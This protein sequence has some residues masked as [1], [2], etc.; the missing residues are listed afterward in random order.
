MKM[1]HPIL[2]AGKTGQ[3]AR[4]TA[5]LATERELPLVTVGRPELDLEDADSV[6]RVMA[7]LIPSAIVNAAA[8]TLV[9]KAESESERAFSINRDGAARLAAAAAKYRIPYVHVST[10]YVF[11]GNK[12]S[13][14]RE[15]DIPSPLSIYG[16]S[17]LAGE[18]AVR[19][20]Y[21]E[22]LILRTS[23]V[24]SHFGQ[25][26]VKTMLRLADTRDIVRVVDDQ[27]GAPTAANDLARAILAV[28]EQIAKTGDTNRAGVYHVACGGETTWYGFAAAIYADWARRGRR[29]PKLEPIKT[30]DYPTPAQRPANSRLDCLKIRRTFGIQ[31]PPWQKS[32]EK[33]LD[34]LATASLETK[35]C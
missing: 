18:I 7:A 1:A 14:Y 26:F 34:R 9:D 33:C 11:D 22:A 3:L 8:Y 21:S 13:P 15:D 30:A 6:E 10:D 16:Q 32:L 24:F 25:N 28:L 35:Q 27:H 2:V 17:K 20:A 12:T 4:A 23:W 5:E 31:L 29:I 19:N